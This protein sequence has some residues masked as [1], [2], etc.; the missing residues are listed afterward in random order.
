M[1]ELDVVLERLARQLPQAS[2][3]ECRIFAELLALPDPLLARYLLAG[4]PPAEP[5]LAE[6]IARVRAL[7]RLNDG[8]AV[9]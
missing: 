1:K 2:A 5:H 9:F 3:A 7:C 8:Q 4:D 6:A